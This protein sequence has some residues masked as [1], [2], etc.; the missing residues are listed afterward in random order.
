MTTNNPKFK[1]GTYHVDAPG[2]NGTFPIEVT[3]SED[4]IESVK[5][6]G[7]TETDG[8]GSNAYTTM[9]QQ[10]VDGQTLNV[11][12]VTGASDTSHG[13]LSGVAEAIKQAGVD[14][15]IIKDRPHYVDPDAEVEDLDYTTDIV[16]IGGGGAGLAAAATALDQGKK[17]VLLEKTMALGG[18]T[19]RAGGPMNAADPEWQ[20]QFK[21]CQAKIRRLRSLRNTIWTK[22]TMSIKLTLKP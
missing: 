19:V 20:N 9:P 5:V 22:W 1:P 6:D 2:H 13:I 11:D 16:V 14:P 12:V 8:I 17:V 21:L 15:E 3:F 4:R 10:I 18:N 7:K